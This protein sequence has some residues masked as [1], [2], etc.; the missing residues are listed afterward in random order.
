MLWHSLLDR[1]PH[2]TCCIQ[3][4]SAQLITM[5]Q[6]ACCGLRML[7][8]FMP[9]GGCSVYASAILA[10][11]FAWRTREGLRASACL[12]SWRQL[13]PSLDGLCI[14]NM[15][16]NREH[17]AFVPNLGPHLLPHSG[18]TSLCLSCHLSSAS[19]LYSCDPIGSNSFCLSLTLVLVL[20]SALKVDGVLL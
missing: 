19:R 10:S 2:F 17:V 18:W 14:G 16:N 15:H 20:Y 13:A 3:R 7:G 9:R 11:F 12:P 8:K 6:L 5:S 4:V 1:W